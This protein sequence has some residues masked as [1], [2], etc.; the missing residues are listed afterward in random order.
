M[1]E[2]QLE[3]L[4]LRNEREGH[5]FISGGAAGYY[6]SDGRILLYSRQPREEELQKGREPSIERVQEIIEA[7]ERSV[8]GSITADELETGLKGV[9]KNIR[10]CD[11][12]RPPIVGW[13]GGPV[14]IIECEDGWE[15]ITAAARCEA[16]VNGEPAA[17]AINAVYMAAAAP[18]GGQVWVT[19]KESIL[20]NT[21][22]R[23][24][25]R[26]HKLQVVLLGFNSDDEDI[27]A[28]M[29]RAGVTV[30]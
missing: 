16:V 18:A 5:A 17:W 28:L 3:Q 20:Y 1:T 12:P 21:V 22:V 29:L 11:S 23:A 14:G 30:W 4:I 6:A 15:T 24:G 26:R 13:N 9:K 7:H 25:K 27:G 19:D 8:A 10:S 2:K